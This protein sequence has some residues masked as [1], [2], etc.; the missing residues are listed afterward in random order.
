MD[1]DGDMDIVIASFNDDTIRWFEN[2][3][4]TNPSWSATS[5]D[6]SLDGAKQVEVFDLDQDG[7]LDILANSMNDDKIAWF[8]NN[9]AANPSWGSAKIITT[10]F[11]QPHNLFVGDV[12]SDGDLDFVASSHICLLYTSPSPR[13]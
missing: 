11:D 1:A 13:D 12:D 8:E 7:D 4:A 9:G 10:S 3:G 2:N 5:I 6:T